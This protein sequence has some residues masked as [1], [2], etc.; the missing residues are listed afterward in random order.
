MSEAR[1]RVVYSSLA[2]QLQMAAVGSPEYLRLLTEW[3]EDGKT[4]IREFLFRN[5]KTSLEFPQLLD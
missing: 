3:Q 1:F 5:A 2:P 4:D